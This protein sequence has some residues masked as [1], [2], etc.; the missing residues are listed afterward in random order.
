M[1]RFVIKV[2]C[3]ADKSRKNQDHGYHCD[4]VK[5]LNGPVDTLQ[6]LG[7]ALLVLLFSFSWRRRLGK[8]PPAAVLDFLLQVFFGVVL[9]DALSMS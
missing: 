7:K 9:L 5:H 6:P 3:A 8:G 1:R 2:A 4:V